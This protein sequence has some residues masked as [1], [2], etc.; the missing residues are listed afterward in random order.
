MGKIGGI[1]FSRMKSN[2][3]PGKALKIIDGVTLLQRVIDESKK[4]KNINHL[5]VATSL[6]HEDNKIEVFA[7][8]LGID[9]FR[10]SEE[11]VIDR[12]LQASKNFGYKYFAR[13]CGDRPFINHKIYDELLYSHR[14]SDADIT[15]NIFPRSVPF[16]L[17]AEII[18]VKSLDSI[19]DL[20]KNF[21][22]KEHITKFFYDNHH[23]FK[24]NAVNHKNIFLKDVKTRLV[25]DNEDDLKK[26]N[27]IIEK[28]VEHKM[29]LSSK[30]IIKMANKWE[31]NFSTNN[32][33]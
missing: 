7:N 8:K 10:G 28:H 13:I 5:C 1:I 17:S 30:S 26:V 2:R 25:V 24:I 23:D 4:I 31:F 19:N 12:A 21:S 18:K 16:G 3:L 29:N 6:S 27:W 14:T 20:I 15:T 32:I 9:V 11:D 33:N 22:D